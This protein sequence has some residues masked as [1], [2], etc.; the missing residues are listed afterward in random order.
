MKKTWIISEVFHPN[1]G[2][3]SYYMTK[4]AESLSKKFNVNVITTTEGD[5]AYG[6]IKIN[7]TIYQPKTRETLYLRFQRT[8]VSFLRILFMASVKV[9]SGD[10]VMCVTNPP[11]M[12]NFIAL[13]C[14]LRGAKCI[15]RID[16][17]YPEALVAAGI[18]KNIR[19]IKVLRLL[20]RGFYPLATR[21]IVLGSDMKDVLSSCN[22][23]IVVIPNWGETES[24]VL[25]TK[26][27]NVLIKKYSL[28]NKFVVLLAGTIG[29]V[30]GIDT[31]L[32]TAEAL[33]NND[34]IRFL[35][36]GSG[37]KEEWLKN[38]IKQ[39]DLTNIILG[40]P[41]SKSN[42]N[43]FL[44][45]CD[46]A[47]V[48]LKPQMYGLGVPSRFYNYAAAGKPIVA[49]LDGNSEI[50]NVIKRNDIGRIVSPGNPFELKSTLIEL[51]EMDE[52]TLLGMG[53]KARQIVSENYTSE[54]ILD[55]Y[56]E[57]FTEMESDS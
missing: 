20:F 56:L 24:V 3:T 37:S 19:L 36:V 4:I 44:N 43:T 57:L 22:N 46:V 47:L 29:Y 23:N 45:A 14:F 31:V 15:I 7:R 2:A 32:E 55:R 48:A 53:E 50:S 51:S 35:I 17:V 6:S 28:E 34:Q 5:S 13:I 33:K 26:K 30:Q 21:I 12:P 9:K 49:V 27:E 1:E 10:T 8:L 11:L 16:D 25:E 18:V 41:F 54:I 40:G 52:A 38:Q 39:R 42:Q